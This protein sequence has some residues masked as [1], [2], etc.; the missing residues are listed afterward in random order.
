MT[1]H[2]YLYELL[3]RAG[4]SDFAA[5]S[6]EFLLVRPLRLLMMVVVAWVLARIGSRAARRFVRS[7]HARSPMRAGSPRAEQRAHT[8]GDALAGFVAVAVW[9][10][11]VLV[12]L[13]EVG[14]DLRPLLAG[15]GIVGLALGFGAQSLVRDFLSGLFILVE[16][17]YGIGD[18]IDLGDRQQGTVEEIGLR[19]TRI[20]AADATVWFVPNGEVRRVGNTSMGFSKAVVDVLL[21]A[22]AD[23]RKALAVMS[24]EVEE[25]VSD[26]DW[27]DARLSAPEVCGVQASGAEGVTLRIVVT[28]APREQFAVARELRRRV[29]ARLR[30]DGFPLPGAPIPTPATPQRRSRK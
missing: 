20:R 17:Q 23:T 25:L 14:V 13:G 16:D 30:E 10:I 9:S 29:L 7:V 1:D 5:T 12:I 27:H 24:E 11:A 19:V 18:V 2:G 22:S 8:V 4:V 15:A 28:T 21:L 3:R 26:P 6:A